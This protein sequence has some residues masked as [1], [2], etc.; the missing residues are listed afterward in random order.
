MLN[1]T[2]LLVKENLNDIIA[3]EA[4]IE[5][6]GYKTI[7]VSAVIDFDFLQSAETK[8][9]LILC[10]YSQIVL[11]SG[12]QTNGME[13]PCL[14]I[15]DTNEKIISASSLTQKVAYLNQPFSRAVL[16]T[17]IDILIAAKD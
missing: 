16:K 7:T 15:S 13:L 4:M 14:L 8:I 12:A 1:A 9:D 17:I 10:H 5:E 3:I 6:S 2:I 11:F